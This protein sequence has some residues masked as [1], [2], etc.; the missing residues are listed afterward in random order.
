[1]FARFLSWLA[2]GVASGF[3]VVASMAF[4]RFD[5]SNVALGVGIGILVVSLFLA[6]C[7][8]HSAST[9]ATALASAIVSG[10]T[11]VASQAFGLGE[12]QN[13]TFAGGLAL[14]A[15]WRSGSRCTS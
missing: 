10:W 11:V 5:T 12:V 1:M 4:A 8:R 6:Y 14:A 7:Y 13:R 2:L 15:L 3:L 9:V